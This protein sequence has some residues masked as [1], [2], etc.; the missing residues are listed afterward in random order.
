MMSAVEP[1][2]IGIVTVSDRASRGEYEDRG[3]PAVRQYLDEVLVGPWHAEMRMVPDER[4]QIEAALIALADAGCCLV[5]TTGGT[6]P[7]PRDVTPEATEAVCDKLLAGFGEQMRAVSLRYVPTAI[8]SR[9]IAGI[10]G[11]TL[12]I[13]LPGSPKAIAECLDA[14]FAA[15]PDCVDLIG[16][17]RLQ[18][19]PERVAAF[20]P[21]ER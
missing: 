15:V 5:I 9:Q 21:H 7:A 20:R 17:P 10:R 12:Y 18:T 4:P 2:R 11:E 13:N 3:G 1:T 16:G 6:G 14:V 19:N 8:L